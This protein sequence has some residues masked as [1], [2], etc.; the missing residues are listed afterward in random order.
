MICS[1]VLTLG[2]QQQLRYIDNRFLL[3]HNS[4]TTLASLILT[5]ESCLAKK[6]GLL[7]P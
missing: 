4:R 5:V 1:G 6:G 3:I 2:L 7:A